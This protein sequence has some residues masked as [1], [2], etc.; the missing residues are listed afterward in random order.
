MF[1]RSALTGML[2]LIAVGVTQA[3]AADRA[4]ATL[5]IDVI[6][7]PVVSV[8]PATKVEANEGVTFQLTSPVKMT[9]KRDER[10][11]PSTTEGKQDKSASV[12]RTV[13]YT[14]D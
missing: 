3:L 11:L 6:V 13:T 1:R 12:L 7:K 2:L 8:P 9:V 5:R 4:S 10:T 14:V